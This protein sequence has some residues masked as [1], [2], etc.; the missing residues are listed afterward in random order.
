MPGQA[1]QVIATLDTSGR[2]VRLPD[3]SLHLYT[4]STARADRSCD[5]MLSVS[6]DH[7]GGWSNPTALLTLDGGIGGWGCVD[8]LF[9]DRGYI[10]LF[11]LND[12]NT[13]VFEKVV[14]EMDAA[15]SSLG[16]RIIDIWH[17]RSTS[18]VGSAAKAG[19]TPP[20]CVWQGYTGSLNSIYQLRTGGIV[21]PFS[22]TTDRHWFNRWPGLEN[23]TFHGNFVCTVLYSED[24]GES[25]R[26]GTPNLRVPVPDPTGAYGAVE[27]VAIE[28]QDGTSWMLLRTQMGRFY[29]SLSSDGEH[30]SAPRPTR[31]ISSDSPAGLVRL[32]DG[33]LVLIW[34]LCQRYP[35]AY[36]GRQVIHAAISDDDGKTWRGFRECAADP[37][38]HEPP[39]NVSGDFGTAYPYPTATADGKLIFVTGQ[40]K[41]RIQLLRLDPNWLLETHVQ[42]TFEDGDA[43]HTFGTA[44]VG[45]APHPDRS[46]AKALRMMRPASGSPCAAVWN[47]P[48]SPRGELTLRLKAMSGARPLRVSLADHFSTP[49]DM[50]D[51]LAS[52]FNVHVSGDSLPADAWCELAIAWDCAGRRVARARVNGKDVGDTPLQHETLGACY[53][54][55]V[56]AA[57]E[58]DAAG[59][60]FDAVTVTIDP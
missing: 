55:L 30:W 37:R 9:D 53:L 31:L 32:D 5:V 21:L 47:F 27:P 59:Y 52:L 35:Y 6:H 54:R 22:H 16:S 34:N 12:R 49:F 45:I 19:W 1:P 14:G 20:R 56:S 38:R 15:K 44:G 17:C 40:G 41:G 39:P 29:E 36:G 18:P 46:G 25:W 8:S 11:L 24:H 3:G 51:G 4:L 43:W 7:G 50:E 23:F 13:G 2:I 42:C 48:L 26:T 57:D 28:R 58:A 60:W 33:R 10:H